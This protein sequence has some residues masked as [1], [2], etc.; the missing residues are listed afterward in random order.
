LAILA[1]TRRAGNGS[2]D[3]Y[4]TRSM[5]VSPFDRRLQMGSTLKD[6]IRGDLPLARAIFN[7]PRKRRLIPRLQRDG[8]PIFDLAG[9][10]CAFP[11]DLAAHVRKTTRSGPAP[12]GAAKANRARRNAD[13]AASTA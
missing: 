2:F 13:S 4:D 9:K 7:D 3:I 12:R 5:V 11:A 1:E 8:W 10:R 6:L